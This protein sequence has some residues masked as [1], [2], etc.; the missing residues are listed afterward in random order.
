MDDLSLEIGFQLIP[1][2]DEKQ[3][4]QMLARVRTLRRHLAG[5]LGFLVP[6]IHI[7]DNLRLKPREYVFSVRGTRDRAL[8]DRG[9]LPSG[10]ERR[11][12]DA[13]LARQGDARAGLRRRRALDRARA[14]RSGHGRRL[15]SR[16]HRHRDQH[17]S[18]PR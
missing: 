13:P 18:S 7:S 8:A 3:G 6:P 16:R 2:V 12:H 10:S 15:L 11:G 4:G 9:Q 1:L 5:E 17:P 14:R